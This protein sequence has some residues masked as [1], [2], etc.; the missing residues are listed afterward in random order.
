MKYIKT[1][2][3]FVFFFLLFFIFYISIYHYSVR[4]REDTRFGNSFLA[5][6]DSIAK[7]AQESAYIPANIPSVLT[8]S[9]LDRKAFYIRIDK[10][11][12]FKPIVKNV[13]PRFKEEYQNS[14]ET[15]VSHGKFTALPDQIGNTYLF[16]HAVS[17]E[18]FIEANNA[19]FSL[20]DQLENDDE[21]IIY[22]EGKKYIYQ[23]S[24]I[25]FIKPSDTSVYTGVSP[26]AKVTLQ[27]CG[28]PRGSVDSRYMVEALLVSSAE[29]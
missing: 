5:S 7:T 20:I 14:W 27:T 2:F 11:G 19:W 13:D 26:V 22:Y 24:R 9:N 17:D 23:V 8:E 3:K 1:F 21:I 18:R 15:G 6:E 28:P 25:Y 10:I 12:L 29:Y 4:S 16:A